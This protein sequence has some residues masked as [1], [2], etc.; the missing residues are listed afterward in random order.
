VKNDALYNPELVR[1]LFDEMS[2]TYGMMNLLSSFGFSCWWRRQCIAELELLE[3]ATIVDLMAG[4]GE[5]S[6][7]LQKWCRSSKRIIALDNWPAMCRRAEQNA[8][9]RNFHVIEADALDCPLGDSSVDTI[10]ST[11]GL[12]TFNNAQLSSLAREVFRILRPGGT[13]AFLEISVP[14]H[15]LLRISFMFYLQHVVP[16]LGRLFFGNADNYRMLGIY[17]SEFHSCK[18]AGLLFEEAGLILDFRSYFFGCA[19][20]FVGFKP[21]QTGGKSSDAPARIN[22]VGANS[23]PTL[24][25]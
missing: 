21:I 15:L 20:G 12:K 13:F 9:S 16:L 3:N 17:T 23:T 11:F 25:A 6:C 14:P 2:G 18:T 24:A 10:F 1:S 22:G 19:T 7:E 8:L 5:L 4:M